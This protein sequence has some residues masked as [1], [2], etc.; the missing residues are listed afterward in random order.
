MRRGQAQDLRAAA[1][2]ALSRVEGG[3]GAG[4]R[5]RAPREDTSKSWQGAMC[6]GTRTD[7]WCPAKRQ[8]G[9]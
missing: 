8:A 2:R 1:R 7:P 4:H 9:G 5:Q 3:G 6:G